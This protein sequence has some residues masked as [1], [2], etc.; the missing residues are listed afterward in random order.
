MDQRAV[1]E[2]AEMRARQDAEFIRQ[3][4]GWPLMSALPLQH[5][6]WLK[7]NRPA[8]FKATRHF[9]FVNDFIGRRLTGQLCM[10]P[11]DASITQLM[12]LATGDWDE[13]LLAT[14]GI[15]RDQLS[16]IR[17]SGFVIGRLNREASAVSGLP[18]GTLVVNGAHDQYCA[19][20]G[21]GVTR[22]GDVLLSC[23]TAWVI[24]AVPDDLETGLRSGLALSRHAVEGRFGAIRS[25]GAVGTSLEWLAD[26]IW[27]GSQT[28]EGRDAIYRAIDEEVARSRPGAGELQFF[29]LAGGHRADYGPGRGGFLG[30]TIT[31][32][33]GDLGRAVMEGTVFELRKVLEEIRASGVE[34]AELKMV[35]GAAKSAAWPQIIADITG[36]PVTL[37]PIRDAAAWGAAVL[38]G[39]GAGLLADPEVG[40]PALA[41]GKTHLHPTVE[42]KQLY[43]DL[44]D[45]HVKLSRLLAIGSL[46]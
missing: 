4:T 10:N 26:N 31:H 14:A 21:T 29:P 45:R 32:G 13:R 27:G 7:R 38:A 25:L 12:N 36:I 15:E 20:V 9:L 37:L 40:F 46:P 44:F 41:D 22:P 33:R 34:V 24:L 43:D 39:V 8:E 19:A 3:T 18:E 2:A 6:R 17:P 11:S 5:I 16:P 1:E 42:R 35:G 28:G 30:L 23:G